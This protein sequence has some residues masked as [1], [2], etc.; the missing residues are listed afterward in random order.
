MR[1][2]RGKRPDSGF[3]IVS[4]EVLRDARI[5]ER[6]RGLLVRILSYPD[7]WQT[8]STALAE[9]C[10]EG[11][12]AI[13]T[14]MRELE[15]A[16]YM[17]RERRRADGGRWVTDTVVYD[18]A[19][20][21]DS[22]AESGD[23]SGRTSGGTEHPAGGVV[24]PASRTLANPRERVSGTLPGGSTPDLT[25]GF[26]DGDSTTRSSS[27][28][29][30][31]TAV[32]TGLLADRSSDGLP[33]PWDPPDKTYAQVTPGTGFQSSENQASVNQSSE[34]Q[35][36]ETQALSTEDCYEDALGNALGRDVVAPQIEDQPTEQTESWRQQDRRLFK[37]L[38][39]AECAEVVKHSPR[40]RPGHFTAEVLYKALAKPIEGDDR[41]V[42][43]Y[44]GMVLQFKDE[45]GQL[46]DWLW[47]TGI[48][49][50]TNG[51]A[52]RRGRSA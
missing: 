38:L 8:D 52:A 5:S 13:R 18:K 45:T 17:R 27:T 15:A 29:A 9:Q 35:A 47:E 31:A 30:S 32:A 37:E 20:R 26:A 34:D 49:P 16:G 2:V 4:H 28:Q 12:D 7:D 43:R 25:S 6:A 24:H 10:R 36:S 44:P 42:M 51:H 14:A 39:G 1:I 23:L 50:C 11:R 46:E 48:E 41:Q 22:G 40:W 33:D 19:V 21:S 3:L